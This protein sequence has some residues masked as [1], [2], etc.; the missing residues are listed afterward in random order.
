MIYEKSREEE[1]MRR[2]DREITEAAEIKR[3]LDAC[4]VCR[5]GFADEESVYIVPMNYGYCFEDGRL[6]LYFHGAKEGRKMD[7]VRKEPSVGIEMDCGHEL[8][9]GKLACQYSYHYASIIGRGKAAEV[10]EP[11]E[12]LKALGLIMKH[13]T[14][15]EFDEFE[16]NPKL[17]KAVAIIRVE[18]EKY[19]CKQYV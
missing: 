4:K 6:I 1:D 7:L 10:V 18:V 5:L 11:E 9:E 12:K 8:V 14:G 15:K 17:E 19:S 13:Q 16:T 2:K 3:I